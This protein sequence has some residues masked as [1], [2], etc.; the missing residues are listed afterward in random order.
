MNVEITRNGVELGDLASKKLARDTAKVEQM[1]ARYHPD[2][3]ALH[4]VLDDKSRKNNVLAKLTLSLM[5]R[6]LHVEAVAKDVP[7]ATN[8]AFRRLYREIK[9]YKEMIRHE[10]D[11]SRKRSDFAPLVATVDLTA[12]AREAF[13]RFLNNNYD[14]LFAYTERELRGRVGQ[15]MIG[16]HSTSPSDILDESVAEVLE[17]VGDE[18]EERNLLRRMYSAIARRVGELVQSSGPAT[19]SIERIVRPR[20]PGDDD[21]FE[22]Y[23]PDEVTSL[24]DILADPR[25]LSA[26]DRAEREL[27][28]EQIEQL[29]SSLPA[30]WREAFVLSREEGFSEEEVA[31]M[32][33]CGVDTV[34]ERIEL[35]R[36]FLRGRLSELGLGGE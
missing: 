27:L 24:E 13:V 20:K 18:Y 35:A 36:R 16:A 1:L 3:A 25:E 11:Y 26:E 22:F 32:Q 23:Q 31:M 17:H 7:T 5:R 33:G 28:A 6:R 14:R 15:R 10:P 4:I 34:K 19:E 2:A 12:E 29:T 8:Q 30:S 9:Q 21:Y